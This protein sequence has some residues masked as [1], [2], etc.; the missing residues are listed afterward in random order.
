MP[1]LGGSPSFGFSKKAPAIQ[2]PPEKV[3][4]MVL[5]NQIVSVLLPHGTNR[6]AETRLPKQHRASPKPGYANEP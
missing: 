5:R 6:A 2:G 4:I 3:G 1:T